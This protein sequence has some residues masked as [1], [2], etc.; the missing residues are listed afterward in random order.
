[1][2]AAVLM[3]AASDTS[4]T[5][6]AGRCARPAR[7]P[8]TNV[9]PAPS[10]DSIRTS[11]PCSRVSSWT[12]ASP[13]PVPSCVRERASRTRWKRSNSRGTS[14]GAMPIPVSDTASSALAPV[15]RSVTPMRPANVCLNAFESRFTTTFSHISRST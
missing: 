10:S 9:L 1:M 13:I 5:C 11:P 6:S 15:Q 7:T 4:P 8:A 2:A 14:S 12:I 3:A